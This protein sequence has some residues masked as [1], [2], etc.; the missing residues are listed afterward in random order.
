M[1]KI[2]LATLIAF[3]GLSCNKKEVVT[4]EE[5]FETDTIVAPETYEPAIS[6]K[7]VEFSP[8]QISDFL[9]AKNNDTLYVTNFFATWCGPC[10]REFPHF[11]EKMEELKNQPVKWTFVSLDKRTDW[12]TEVKTFAEEKGLTE[13]IILLDG[14]ALGADFFS[15]NFKNW[16]GSGIP[17]TFMRKGEKTD[18]YMSMMTKEQLDQKIASFGINAEN[19]AVSGEN[20][21]SK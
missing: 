14:A 3:V 9:S 21:K 17:F 15:K 18:E 7:E 19:S 11:Q 6:F 1:K 16:D 5:N 8:D 4:T 10:M 12:S 20:K 2:V 13:N